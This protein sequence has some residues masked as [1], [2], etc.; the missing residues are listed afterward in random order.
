MGF[1]CKS[2]NAVFRLGLGIQLTFGFA[3]AFRNGFGL[4]SLCRSLLDLTG[5]AGG[6]AIRVGVLGATLGPGRIAIWILI[7]ALVAITIRL[8]IAA[9]IAIRTAAL[10]MLLPGWGPQ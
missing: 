1:A 7:D 6:I 10:A 4:R 2:N 9:P 8:G 3:Q 5:G